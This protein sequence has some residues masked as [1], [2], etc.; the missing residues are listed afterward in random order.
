MGD[1]RKAQHLKD[2]ILTELRKP[3]ADNDGG[4]RAVY[5]AAIRNADSTFYYIDRMI[6][7]R[8]GMLFSVGIPCFPLFDFIHNDPRWTP[9]LERIN[10]RTCEGL[11]PIR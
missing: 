7:N 5:F 10:A 11:S 9:V 1:A 6:T 4:R 8:G 2:S 3:N